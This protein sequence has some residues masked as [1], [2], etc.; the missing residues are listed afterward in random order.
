MCLREREEIMV[1]KKIGNRVYTRFAHAFTKIEANK[2]ETELEEMGYL[3]KVIDS[4]TPAIKGYELW[5]AK[6]RK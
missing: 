2:Y 5:I 1:A 6:R 3:V 4:T